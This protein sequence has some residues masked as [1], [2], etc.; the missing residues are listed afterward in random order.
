MTDAAIDLAQALGAYGAPA[1]DW[2]S[3]TTSDLVDTFTDAMT[4][5]P[6]EAWLL[7]G[8]VAVAFWSTF[9]RRL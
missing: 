1:V 7:F 5:S 2:I 8:V 4:N 3:S 9:F 6:P